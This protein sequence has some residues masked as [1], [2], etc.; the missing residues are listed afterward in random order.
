M[1]KH[2]MGIAFFLVVLAAGLLWIIFHLFEADYDAKRDIIPILILNAPQNNRQAGGPILFRSNVV[3]LGNGQVRSLGK[4]LAAE[5]ADDLCLK[6]IIRTARI[7][8]PHVEG[9]SKDI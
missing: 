1:S 6:V 7:C 5:L 9:T 3:V 4:G 2:L 8:G